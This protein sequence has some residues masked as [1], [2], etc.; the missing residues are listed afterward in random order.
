VSTADS[1]GR[2]V[3]SSTQ[4]RRGEGGALKRLADPGQS[5]RPVPTGREAAPAGREASPTR[6]TAAPGR[7]GE[8]RTANGCFDGIDNDT[9][10]LTD[11][12]DSDC[13]GRTCRQSLGVCDP[14]ELCAAGVCPSDAKA[15]QTQSCRPSAGSCDL[16][17]RCDGLSAACPTDI[18]R[19]GTECRAA[20]GECDVA[21]VCTGVSATCP[22]DAFQPAT[23]SCRAA[24]GACD[25]EDF[26]S[27]DGGVCPDLIA[28]VTST[29]RALA[30]LAT[31]PSAVTASP[32]AVQLTASPTRE[33]C[34]AP[35]MVAVT[36]P[37]SAL[38]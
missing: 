37:R 28:P 16:E 27:G 7:T 30:A 34:A 5:T 23:R 20:M 35:S 14:V 3:R 11:C 25:V 18:F 10:M 15:P 26:C 38:E 24:S 36:C 32:R 21:E 8:A 1:A 12:E 29:C 33:R 6:P 22:D 9:D 19:Q 17:E 13:E 4:P 31:T 2:P